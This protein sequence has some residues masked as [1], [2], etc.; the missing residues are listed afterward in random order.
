MVL[1]KV[2]KRY[3]W[4][5]KTIVI[6]KTTGL[7]LSTW[8]ETIGVTIK[9]PSPQMLLNIEVV[10]LGNL[11]GTNITSIMSPFFNYSFISS[12]KPSNSYQYKPSIILSFTKPKK[13]KKKV[14]PF[15]SQF[16]Q[17]LTGMEIVNM[18]QKF[19]AIDAQSNDFFF[20]LIK[21]VLFL[22]STITKGRTN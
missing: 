5:Y 18:S 10:S 3:F 4:P 14:S 8:C 20:F 9:W 15:C 2:R 22:W 17:T 21:A 11:G 16:S 1:W 7:R 12:I 6:K 13:K 19:S